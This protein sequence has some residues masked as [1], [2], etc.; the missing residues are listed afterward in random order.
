MTILKFL[1]SPSRPIY[2]LK[3]SDSFFNISIEVSLGI[4]AILEGGRERGCDEEI[5]FFLS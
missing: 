3:F 5:R 2:N 4:K 1:Q